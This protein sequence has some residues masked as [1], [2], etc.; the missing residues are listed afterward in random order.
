MT[1]HQFVVANDLKQA[2]AIILRKKLLGMVD[3]YAIFLG[4]R[5]SNPVFVANYRD[6]V[7][8]VSYKELSTILQTYQPEQIDRFPGPEAHRQLAVQRAL[9]RIGERAYN[10]IANNCEHFKN[11]VH[12]GEN[13]SQQVKNAGDVSLGIAAVAGVAAIGAKSEKAALVG[14]GFLLAGLLLREAAKD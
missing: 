2:D 11:W 9:S 12:H 14:M 5:N 7:K 3:H 1:L 13:R 10:Y 6:G 4:Y 8:E